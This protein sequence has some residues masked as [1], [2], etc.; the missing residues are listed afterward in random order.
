M[1][2]LIIT[3]F[4]FIGLL[5]TFS[6]TPEIYPGFP[7]MIGAKPT[8]YFNSSANPLI[9]DLFKTGQKII[10]TAG[11]DDNA[12]LQKPSVVY[13][14]TNEGNDLPGFPK[15]FMPDSY[16]FG[17]AAGD[18]DKDGYIDIVVRTTDS[19]YA[20]NRLGANISGFPI[21]CKTNFSTINWVL[22]NF[23][24]LYDLD[25]DQKLEIITGDYNKLY[26]FNNLGG[27]K[28]GWPQTIKGR[29]RFAPAIGDIDLDGKAEIIYSS[30]RELTPPLNLDS[31]NLNILK[32]NGERFS[33][34]FPI[35]LDSNYINT[36]AS[37]T[38]YIDK[39]NIN[40]TFIA[41]PSA[42]NLGKNRLE[43]FNTLGQVIERKVH[44]DRVAI[45]SMVMGD[46]DGDSKLEFCSGNSSG[47]F[48]QASLISNDLNISGGWP[49]YGNVGY[50]TAVISKLTTGKE[51]NVL[52]RSDW[53]I[54]PNGS[55]YLYAYDKNGVQLSW[56][57]LRTQ[58]ACVCVAVDDINSDGSMEIITTGAPYDSN[59]TVNIWT[60]PGVSF[61]PSNSPWPMYAHDR[62]RTNQ[63]G[64]IPP[65][66]T[67]G[68]FPISSNVPDKFSLHQNYPNPFNPNT[69]IKFDLTKSEYVSLKVFDIS[70]REVSALINENLK[71]GTYQVPFNAG[72]LSSG[73]YFYQLRT[74]SSI[75][76][77][78]MSLIK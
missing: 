13:A 68:I 36:F 7:K 50:S 1:K 49:Q 70:G 30:F 45:G 51:L 42:I 35:Y 73:V 15:S 61:S 37:P 27:L 52:V 8:F 43:K 21:Y 66:E 58:G 48:M 24:S 40:S 77:K 55:G 17:V 4:L 47:E 59:L 3:A 5:D 39:S 64:F 14:V 10:I 31:T 25:G 11:Y 20:F 33:N 76:T 78:K 32:Y 65:D 53:A 9:A 28:S 44:V 74:N 34:N 62:Y 38:L 60:V 63:Y 71:A 16:I 18:I 19:I 23:L 46:I 72:E 12:V 69:T 26:V 29:I 6:Q 57:P 75:E 67:V 41:M 56:S 2:K 54:N 22:T